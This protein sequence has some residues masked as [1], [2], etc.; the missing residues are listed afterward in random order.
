MQRRCTPPVAQVK[1]GHLFRA[2][3][4]KRGNF[5]NPSCMFLRFETVFVK[6]VKD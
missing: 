6:I 5:P 3:E 2:L 1:F 4:S